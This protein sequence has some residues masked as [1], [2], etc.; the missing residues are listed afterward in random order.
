MD[1]R[2]RAP[3]RVRHNPDEKPRGMESIGA[4]LPRTAREYGLEEQLEQAEVAAA[5][6]RVVAARVPAAAGACRLVAFE[7]GVAT[8]EAD[9]PIVGQEIRLRAPELLSALRS[10][11]RTPVVQLQVTARHV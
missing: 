11:V 7:R 5:W 1:S 2:G 10:N 3:D 8:V 9:L 6:D 4:L